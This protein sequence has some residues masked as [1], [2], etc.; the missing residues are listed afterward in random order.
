VS[1]ELIR[2]T[3]EDASLCKVA[4]RVASATTGRPDL[5][6]EYI[7]LADILETKLKKMRN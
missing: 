7:E 3:Y 2:L 6:P 5:S 4:L 1:E